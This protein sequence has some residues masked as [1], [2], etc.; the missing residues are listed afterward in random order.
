MASVKKL[1]K[2]LK[3]LALDLLDELN[4]YTRFHPDTDEKLIRKIKSEILSTWNTY[5]HDINALKK[6]KDK[7]DVK[8]EFSNIISEI[9]K[10]MI[11]LLDQLSK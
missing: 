3:T 11:P 6:Q 9:K 1:K 4:I 7:K 8:K 2:Q 10:K 5:I